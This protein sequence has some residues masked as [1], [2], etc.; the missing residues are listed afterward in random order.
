VVEAFRRVD[1]GKGFQAVPAAPA[2]LQ[3]Q[4]KY[5][6]PA[7]TNLVLFTFFDYADPD[8]GKTAGEAFSALKAP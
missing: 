4:L 1:G 7:F 8:L 3:E 6:H 5:A 2:R